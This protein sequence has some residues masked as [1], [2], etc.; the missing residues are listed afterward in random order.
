MD[1]GQAAALI[2][3]LRA[4]EE[5][6]QKGYPSEL[7]DW[8]QD[9]TIDTIIG[10]L[11]ARMADGEIVHDSR[12]TCRFRRGEEAA[13]MVVTDRCVWISYYKTK[14]PSTVTTVPFGTPVQPDGKR[15]P[16][17]EAGVLHI[18]GRLVGQAQMWLTGT[19]PKAPW[20][21]ALGTTPPGWF[22]DPHGRHQYRWWSGA[23][24]TLQVA[25]NGVAGTELPARP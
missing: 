20:M 22:P 13:L 23:E 18:D 21:P 10:G 4:Q 2:A 14:E 15:L 9:A 19:T 6:T 3:Q 7:Y 24:W 1:E 25:D 16:A 11:S 17:L 12:W 5:A 8:L